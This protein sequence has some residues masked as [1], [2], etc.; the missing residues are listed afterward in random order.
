[1]DLLFVL[2]SLVAVAVEE[3]VRLPKMIE[4]LAVE[5]VAVELVAL[6]VMVDKV[7]ILEE[8]LV[9]EQVNLVEQVPKPLEVVAVAVVIMGVK[10]VDDLVVQVVKRQV[11]LEVVEM[12]T[13]LVDLVVEM[14]LQ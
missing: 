6:L 7:E 13:H 1:M 5:A 11:T 9:Q 2:V 8:D 12:V 3:V 14:E 10:Q 4:E